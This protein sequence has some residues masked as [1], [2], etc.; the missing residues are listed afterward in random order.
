LP[1]SLP[2]FLATF[3]LAAQ[4]PDPREI[5]R[6]SAAF[7]ARDIELIRN[8]TFL[9]H[10]EERKLDGKGSPSKVERTTHEIVVLYGRPYSRLMAR[11]GKPL[12]DRE[13]RKE[14]EK[15]DKEMA[16]RQKESEKDR[17]KRLAEEKKD[18]EEER[19][20]R[21]EVAEAYEFKLLGDESVGGH[22][23]WVIQADPKPGFQPRSGDGKILKKI[24]GK[25]WVSKADHRWVKLDAEVI[26][27]VSFGWML[28]RLYPGTRLAF[29]AVKAGGEVWMPG[30]AF[31]RGNGR[32]ALLKK[33]DVEVESRWDNYRKFQTES[34]IV[35]AGEA[36]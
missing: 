29:E 8:Y 19:Q 25:L 23:A 4:E 6:Q 15:L 28:L 1:R 32:L 21:L 34:R 17:A 9:Q 33:I 3:L 26:D 11:D 12:A 35:A 13:E 22:P 7:E 5:I 20:F 30:H 27:T 18:L 36:Q 31:V 2:F 16:R 24:R 14:Q 10:R